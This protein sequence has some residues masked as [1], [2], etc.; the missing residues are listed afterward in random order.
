[1]NITD[2]R[3]L[4]EFDTHSPTV[5]MSVSVRVGCACVCGVICVCVFSVWGV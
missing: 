2:L 1:M 3:Y 5:L 4:I